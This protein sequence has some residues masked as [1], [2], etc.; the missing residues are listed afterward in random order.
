MKFVLQSSV[1]LASKEFTTHSLLTGPPPA[2]AV[3]DTYICSVSYSAGDV[4]ITLEWSDIGAMFID[5]FCV[6]QFNVN[7]PDIP[8]EGTGVHTPVQ[9]YEC[10]GLQEDQSYAFE[11]SA[12]NCGDQEGSTSEPLVVNPRGIHMA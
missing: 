11:V 5:E 4:S 2:P 3:S 8:C 6:E 7:A 9:S 12:V 1:W 10:G